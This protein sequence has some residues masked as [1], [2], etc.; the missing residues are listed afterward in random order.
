[1]CIIMNTWHLALRIY[2]ES[3]QNKKPEESSSN[4]MVPSEGTYEYD[5]VMR[6]KKELDE[7][8]GLR[9]LQEN[10]KSLKN[11]NKIYENMLKSM[12]KSNSEG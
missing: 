1:M 8:E 6:I 3:N 7:D 9:K 4:W 10:L 11:V 5:E 2:N 12:I